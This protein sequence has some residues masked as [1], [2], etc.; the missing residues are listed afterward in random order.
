MYGALDESGNRAGN[1]IKA[2]RIGEYAGMR[3]I[4]RRCADNREYL[5]DLDHRKALA[6][7]IRRAVAECRADGNV[8]QPEVERRLLERGISAVFRHNEDGRLIG[9][10][11]IDHKGKNVYNGSNLSKDLAANSWYA[12]FTEGRTQP[13]PIPE[14]TAPTQENEPTA[15]LAPDLPTPEDVDE[16]EDVVERVSAGDRHERSNSTASHFGLGLF[17]GLA[18]QGGTYEEI[19]PE[20]RLLYKRQKKGKRRKR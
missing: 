10:T 18:R 7:R 15:P 16:Y 11:F 6:G 8:S 13:Q 1:P 12:L 9:A 19:D 4:A 3:E 5:Q 17:E 14:P 20:F 2:S